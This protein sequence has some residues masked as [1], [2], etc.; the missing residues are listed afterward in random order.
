DM[1]GYTSSL[2]AKA[3]ESSTI[4]DEL[5]ADDLEML[6]DY[7]VSW[8]MIS[9]DDLNYTGTSRRGYAVPPDTRAPARSPIHSR[10]RICCRSP[11]RL[12]VP[13]AAT[14]RQ[15]RRPPGRRQ[16]SNARTASASCSTVASA[17]SSASG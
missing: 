15:L 17:S 6:I 11:A 10:L 1:G 8:G 7:L 4:D 12:W 3:A 13:A 14:S 9:S 16:W 5:S 2:L